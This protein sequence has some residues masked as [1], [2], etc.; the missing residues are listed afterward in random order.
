MTTNYAINNQLTT[1]MNQPLEGML[2][3]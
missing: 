2:H 3:D 1:R